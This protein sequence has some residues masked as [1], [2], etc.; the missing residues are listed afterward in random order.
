MR[1]VLLQVE[2][3]SEA[4]DMKEVDST[5]A[6]QRRTSSA[7]DTGKSPKAQVSAVIISGA[8]GVESRTQEPEL[9]LALRMRALEQEMHLQRLGGAPRQRRDSVL[10]PI[11][12]R[13]GRFLLSKNDS[14]MRLDAIHDAEAKRLQDEEKASH[15]AVR[16]A[17][18]TNAL[19]QLRL[20]AELQAQIDRFRER[21]L[22][23][24]ASEPVLGLGAG[25]I[26]SAAPQTTSNDERTQSTAALLSKAERAPVGGADAGSAPH[27]LEERGSRTRP[28][29]IRSRME[30]RA[31]SKMQA[32]DRALKGRLKD[33]T[34]EA[35][36]RLSAALLRLD[37]DDTVK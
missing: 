22:S 25:R 33:R 6:P 31:R 34:W 19:R 30:S 21:R 32:I 9:V 26:P 37:C 5:G 29:N 27:F 28:E 36:T 24:I 20:P 35:A 13:T 7:N 23:T 10:Q 2:A 18:R 17:R 12:V 1:E 16:Q 14:S 11:A 4:P 8:A 15:R 3:E